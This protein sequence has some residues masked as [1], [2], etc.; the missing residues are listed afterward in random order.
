[1]SKD[2]RFTHF[3]FD[4][5]R[6]SEKAKKV[7]GVFN[8]VSENYDIMNDL[9]SLG[10]HRILK[11]IAA[12]QTKL[13]PGEK[14]LDLAGGTGDM[15]LL[16]NRIVSPSGT[17]FVCDINL[18]MLRKG[19]ERLVDKGIIGG[20]EYVRADGEKL[21]FKKNS[22]DAITVSFGIR[23]FTDKQRALESMLEVLDY[24]GRLV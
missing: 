8:S 20:T 21:S 1:M 9:M 24:G 10:T 12:N 16:L 2:N 7:A 23:N 22:F 13:Q 11:R 17:V 19:R 3:G 6:A 5:V 18:N 4:K 15:A 14:V